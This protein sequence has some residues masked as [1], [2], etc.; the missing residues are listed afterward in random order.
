M[1]EYNQLYRIYK[2]Y[3]GTVNI[4]VEQQMYETISV[5]GI[6]DR[7]VWHHNNLICRKL[8]RILIISIRLLAPGQVICIKWA[9][10]KLEEIT[11]ND[12]RKWLHVTDIDFSD[13]KNC[14]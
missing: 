10:A 12:Y 9:I 8:F 7:T 6:L 5:F 1:T 11:N 2:Q 3:V 13:T 14:L 4:V